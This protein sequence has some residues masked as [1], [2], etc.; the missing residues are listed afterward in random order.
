MRLSF[1]KPQSKNIFNKATKIWCFYIFLTTIILVGFNVFLQTE[2]INI[3]KRI[4]RYKH[5]QADIRSKTKA[6]D[7]H[8]ERLIYEATLANNRIDKNNIRKEKIQNLLD[9]IPDK[10]TINSI[11]LSDTRLILKGITPSKDFFRLGL[12]ASLKA[13]FD[14]SNVSF[15]P[16]PNGW[17]QFISISQ[18]NKNKE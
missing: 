10:I 8:Y 7:I 2:I 4:E 15:Y 12:Q 13:N 1:I 11:E 17:H 16:L 3:T 18:N 6:I 9:L 5:D 14:K